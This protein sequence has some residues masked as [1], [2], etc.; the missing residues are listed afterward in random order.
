[1]GLLLVV[2]GGVVVAVREVHFVL[3]CDCGRRGRERAENME[4]KA[5]NLK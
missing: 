1:M 3:L 2:G 5:R 4:K